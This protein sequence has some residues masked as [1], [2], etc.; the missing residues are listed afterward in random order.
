MISNQP[1]ALLHQVQKSDL[2]KKDL[3]PSTRRQFRTWGS[4]SLSTC[5]LTYTDY[6]VL[7]WVKPTQSVR[8]AA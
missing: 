3:H 8:R 2:S 4:R 1:N 7:C 6:C 5:P